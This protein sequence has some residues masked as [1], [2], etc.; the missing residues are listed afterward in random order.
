MVEKSLSLASSFLDSFD[1]TKIKTPNSM[2]YTE[3]ET[4]NIKSNEL[5]DDTIFVMNF[6]KII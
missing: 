2:F 1:F 4:D 3:E 6:S 5:L